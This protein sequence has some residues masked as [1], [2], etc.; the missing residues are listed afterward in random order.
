MNSALNN[1]SIFLDSG[2][3]DFQLLYMI[4]VVC[5]YA[6]TR[7]IKEITFQDEL[8]KKVLEDKVI[9]KLLKLKK[10]TIF[11]KKKLIF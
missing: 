9:N 1:K 2:F 8:P 10:I 5:A 6:D 4:P 7:G 11:K 3:K